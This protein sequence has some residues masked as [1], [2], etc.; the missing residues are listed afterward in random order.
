MAAD[1]QFR[2][3]QLTSNQRFWKAVK[4]VP[5]IQKS[6]QILNVVCSTLS[7]FLQAR[8]DKE[9]DGSMKRRRKGELV[10]AVYL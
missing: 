2:T 10:M 3:L 6:V 7:R 4:Q 5:Q 9:V 1:A 8:S